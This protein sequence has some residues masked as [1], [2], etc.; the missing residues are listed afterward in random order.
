MQGVQHVKRLLD[1][2][3][4]LLTRA[5]ILR[6]LHPLHPVVTHSGHNLLWLDLRL[7]DRWIIGMA[8]LRDR[9]DA[10]MT[11]WNGCGGW[12]RLWCWRIHV[13]DWWRW[14]DMPCRWRGCAVHISGLPDLPEFPDNIDKTRFAEDLSGTV[15][16]VFESYDRVEPTIDVQDEPSVA[17]VLLNAVVG[18][19]ALSPVL[20][21]SGRW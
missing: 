21:D 20:S 14:L 1:S 17:L 19:L 4:N 3:T 11:D 10:H 16:R 13:G 5:L 8:Y 9:G 15:Y 7:H 6:R 2:L 12:F 18:G